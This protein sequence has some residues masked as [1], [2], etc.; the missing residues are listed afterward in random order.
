MYRTFYPGLWNEPSQFVCAF[1]ENS[2]F[3]AKTEEK[4]ILEISVI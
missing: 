2:I 4:E 1:N 3:K